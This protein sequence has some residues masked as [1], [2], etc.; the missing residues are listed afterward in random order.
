MT[1]NRNMS[2]APIQT[3]QQYVYPPGYPP[4]I[5]PTVQPLNLPAPNFYQQPNVTTTQYYQ[6]QP[7]STIPYTTTYLSPV[8]TTQYNIPAVSPNTTTTTY[9]T[10]YPAT[11][12]VNSPTGVT[13]QYG[14]YNLQTMSYI[15]YTSPT[16][17]Q[18][19]VQQPIKK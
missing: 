9:I 14:D 19:Y 15:P 12:Y 2:N 3:Y 4:Q 16:Y 10:T 17:L 1:D 7:G 18:T 11:Y 8:Y 6:Y 5:Q 13:N